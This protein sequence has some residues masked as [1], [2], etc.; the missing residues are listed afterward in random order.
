MS[1]SSISGDFPRIPSSHPTFSDPLPSPSISPSSLQPP[2]ASPSPMSMIQKT[3]IPT[4]NTPQMLLAQ[5]QAAQTAMANIQGHMSHPQLKIRPAQKHLVKNKLA[6]A[7]SSLAAANT[8][9]QGYADSEEEHRPA[10]TQEEIE[11]EPSSSASGPIAQFLH[12]ITDGLHQLESA[13]NQ[14]SAIGKKGK[15]MNAGDFLFVQLKLAK[16]QQELEF[17]SSLLGKA[18]DD[19]KQIMNIQ[20]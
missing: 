4:P 3:M 19:I 17:T 15:E 10:F 9:M 12:Y 6:S 18:I 7:S 13:K 5:L 11:E 8:K 2:S 20:L 16:A 14:I 1:Y